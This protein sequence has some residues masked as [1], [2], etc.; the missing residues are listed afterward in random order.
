[1]TVNSTANPII[2]KPSTTQLAVTGNKNDST[3]GSE[4]TMV[5]DLMKS[6]QNPRVI[7]AFVVGVTLTAIVW[8]L[9]QLCCTKRKSSLH[10]SDTLE[11]V[12]GTALKGISQHDNATQTHD[13]EE[14]EE[15][16]DGA[17][18]KPEVEYS[19]ID[20]SALRKQRSEEEKPRETTESEYAEIKRE[21]MEEQEGE[22]GK[23]E[24]E[25]EKR[26]DEREG[27]GNV[28]EE[29]TEGKTKETL[30]LLTY[31]DV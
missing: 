25:Q 7:I 14:E 10:M 29:Q 11:M 24:G 21:A 20:F 9:T 3:C 6:V 22:G 18:C 15:E 13:G 2:N 8:A 4:M 31:D 27:E 12:S 16:A 19:D 1:M 23:Q 5:D 30:N 26:R 28:E 17:L